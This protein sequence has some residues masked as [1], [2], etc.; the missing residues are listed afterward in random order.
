MSKQWKDFYFRLNFTLFIFCPPYLYAAHGETGWHRCYRLRSCAGMYFWHRHVHLTPPP[1]LHMLQACC[2]RRTSAPPL[3]A[4]RAI[5]SSFCLS[6]THSSRT[7][8]AVCGTA[9]TTNTITRTPA[10]PHSHV[11]LVCIQ[12]GTSVEICGL[13]TAWF[14]DDYF[15]SN[16]C[17]WMRPNRYMGTIHHTRSEWMV[18]G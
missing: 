13:L 16:F 11:H 6:L 4:A 18:D 9:T 12:K 14:C 3:S 2:Q 7:P 15:E 10:R 1:A 5:T 17:S 8:A